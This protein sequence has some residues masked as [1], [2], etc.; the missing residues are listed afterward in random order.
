MSQDFGQ[1]IV[2]PTEST[3]PN[4]KSTVDQRVT[5]FG[6]TKKA[7]LH[8]RAGGWHCSVCEPRYIDRMERL[9]REQ[10]YVS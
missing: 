2:Y 10:G 4:C 9:D 3:C 6:E 7:N 1:R 5:R 8:L